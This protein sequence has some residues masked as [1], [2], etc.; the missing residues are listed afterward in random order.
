MACYIFQH[1]FPDID[2]DTLLKKELVTFD[3]ALK[4]ANSAAL[5]AL[6]TSALLISE[7]L[8]R[9]LNDVD[10]NVKELKVSEVVNILQRYREAKIGFG[11]AYDMSTSISLAIYDCP[12]IGAG[13]KDLDGIVVC[14]LASSNAISSNDVQEFL[15]VF[16]QTTEY[17]GKIIISAVHEPKV[18]AN[19]LVTTI[20]TIG[21]FQQELSPKSSIFSRLAQHFSFVSNL[22][23]KHQPQPSD[24]YENDVL[25]SASPKDPS[26]MKNG[27]AE[28]CP[29]KTAHNHSEEI[30]SNYHDTLISRNHNNGSED[31]DFMLSDDRTSSPSYN[32]DIAEG[33]P[34]FQREALSSWNLGPGH[35][36]A[37]EWAKEKTAETG[38]TSMSDNLSIFSLPVG[39]RPSEELKE[40]ITTQHAS[41]R[42]Q[43]GTFTD[44]GFEVVKEFY[45]NASTLLKGRTDEPKKQGVLSARAASM[46]EA[47]RDAPKKWN[48]V[49]EMQYRGGVY[50]G[51]CQGGLPEGKGRLIFGD[52]SIYDGM[53]HYGKR[54]GLGT[55]YF[56]NGDV[57]QGTWRD[58]LMH[59]KGWF[60]FHTGDRW[61]ANFW[62]GK[63]NGEGRFYSKS[64][65][66]YFG[67]FEDGWRHGRFLCIN[68][69]GERC[70][71]IWNEGVLASREQLDADALSG[72]RI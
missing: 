22:L 59:G 26:E 68:V 15:D 1:L 40:G 18:E 44:S 41:E 34:V 45:S 39:V 65:E 48:P 47:E 17:T 36:I 57:F 69:D 70:I 20:V 11:A 51:H 46:L 9:K 67:R 53:W 21:S 50:K 61:F 72:S 33:S 37:E 8:G 13:I 42:T 7:A 10:S 29:S 28:E 63:A 6:N 71:E 52:G 55:F 62:K 2:T 16:R 64:G 23:N 4:I 32:D 35:Q 24:A 38:A 58:D 43:R 49:L 56:S 5:L 12:F 66:I 30:G 60:Y 3:E 19:L 27:V 31:S 14:V 25:K 54:S